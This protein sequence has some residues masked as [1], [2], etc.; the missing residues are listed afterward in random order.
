MVGE[1]HADAPVRR[2]IHDDAIAQLRDDAGWPA[3]PGLA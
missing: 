3:G 2:P 1:V